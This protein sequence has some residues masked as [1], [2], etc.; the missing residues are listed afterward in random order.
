MRIEFLGAAGTV[1]GSKTLVVEHDT[2][3]LVDCG[4]FQGVKD[5]R[6]RNWEPLGVDPKSLDAVVLTHAH[7]DHSGWLPRLVR[8][9]FRGPIYCTDG[10]ADLCT[11]LLPDSGHIQE[12][13]A[14]YANRRGYSR[15]DPAE[16]L[17]TEREAVQCLSR[18]QRV[19]WGDPV[20]IGALTAIFKPAGHILGASTVRLGNG[21]GSVLFSGDLGR[22]DDP[23]MVAP[24][25]VE[26]A[27]DWLVLESTYGDRKHT[28]TEP[29]SQ[30][31][32]VVK[33]T[34]ERGGVVV[35]PAFAV[36]RAQAVLWALHSLIE[37]GELPAEL[38]IF[39]N[40]P[41]SVDTT[42]L[43]LKHTDLHRLTPEQTRAMCARARFVRTVDESKRL[44]QRTKPAVIISAAGMLTGG[45]VLH[46]LR[47]F[48]P[49]PKNTL[50]LTGFQAAG[51]RGAALL[52]GTRRL[53]IHGRYVDIRCDVERVD[54][55]SAHADADETLA[56]LARWPGPPRHVFLNHGEP[57]AADALRLRIQDEL[58]WSVSVPELGETATLASVEEHP[59]REAAI[60]PV[61]WRQMDEESRVAALL[62]TSGWT[63]ADQD[64][65]LLGSDRGRPL[66]LALEFLKVDDALQRQ[67]VTDTVVVIG[68]TR[69]SDGWWYDQARRFARLASS[70]AVDGLP[71]LVVV[72]GGGP[73]IMEAANRGAFDAGTPTVGLNIALPREQL[74]NPYVT[75]ELCFRLRYFALRKMHFVMRARAFVAFPGGF[76]TLDELF[77][78]LTLVQTGVQPKIPFVLVGEAFWRKA[79]P[80][81]LLIEDGLI[82]PEDAGLMSF[83]DDA[84]A[85]WEVVRRGLAPRFGAQ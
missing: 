8:Q 82:S 65:D 15:H 43:Y 80:L 74:P 21:S 79:L 16:P 44:N 60:P 48:G 76:G 6:R 51:T 55:F 63:R 66:R 57:H 69:T 56:W 29:I 38:P 81:E 58:G 25:T 33:R 17:Y 7:I 20:R 4:L 84:D 12:E 24:Q 39:M 5:L 13:D 1:T 64:L 3:V 59:R 28:G 61:A 62:Q 78:A 49:D 23:L 18:L 45:R 52:R 72:T 32:D 34:V 53:K 40:S 30:L 54:A 47:A 50:L 68:S 71:P 73:G 41:M 77:G 27:P 19:E 31:G 36:G 37:A 46:H 70:T 42:E 11:L 83:V 35:I 10:T 14:R 9:G 26:E 22:P 2:R 85:A 75:P 67:A